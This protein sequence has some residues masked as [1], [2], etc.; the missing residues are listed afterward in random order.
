MMKNSGGYILL[1]LPL[2]IF[3]SFNIEARESR[4]EAIF[5]LVYQKYSSDFIVYIQNDSIYLPFEEVLSY[6][7]IYYIAKE[8]KRFEGY[9]NNA[10]S[11]FVIDFKLKEIKDIQGKVSQLN[12]DLWFA[13][14]FQIFIRTDLLEDLFKLK[15]R[16]LFNSLTISVQSDY[17]LPFLRTI[18]TNQKID[19][20]K[21]NSK[22]EFDF[23]VIS[24]RTFTILNGG[25]IDYTM[26][27]SQS[28][29]YQSYN[30]N[31]NAGL[32]LFSGE[33][34]YNT[35]GRFYTDKFD[36]QD[37]F[38]WRY[39]VD[40]D[41]IQSISLGNIQNMTYRNSSGRGFRKP[42][43]S[44]KGIQITNETSK[45]PNAFTDYVIEDIIEPDWTVELYL[46]DQLYEI[47]KADINGYYRFEIPITYGLTNIKVKLYGERG[48][49]ITEEKVLNIPSQL[50][51]PGELRYSIAAGQDENS[52]VKIA[53]GSINLGVLSWLTT[54]ISAIK[55]EQ[56]DDVYLI[57]QTA[58]NI[59]NNTLLNLTATNRGIFEAGIKLPSNSLG[60]FEIS[61]THFEPNSDFSQKKNSINLIASFNRIFSLPFAFSINGS[62]DAFLNFNTSNIY[63]NLNFYMGGMNFSI[64]HNLTMRDEAL[65]ISN[66]SQNLSINATYTFGNIAKLLSVFR[67]LNLNFS[68]YVNPDNWEIN[69]ISA[70]SQ[71]QLEKN[72][73]INANYI[74]YTYNKLS[75]LK[76]GINMNLAALRSNSNADFNQGRDAVYSTDLSGSVE[77]DSQ[78]LKLSFLNSM[79]SSSIYGKSSA[80]IRFYNDVNYNNTFD[81]EDVLIPEGDFSVMGSLVHK[82]NAGKYKIL[83]NLIPNTKYNIRVNTESFSNPATIPQL[84]EFSFIAAPYS[85]KSIDIACHISG[86]VEGSVLKKTEKGN[87]GFGGM[88]VNIKSKDTTYSTSVLV[89]SDGSYFINGIP[90]GDYIAQLDSNQLM[91]LNSISVPSEIDF[92]IKPSKDGDYIGNISFTIISNDAP[93]KDEP[94]DIDFIS[95]DDEIGGLATSRH[96]PII[97]KMT[98]LKDST[99]AGDKNSKVVKNKK[100][101]AVIDAPKDDIGHG[102]IRPLIFK[103]SRITFLDKEMKLYLDRIAEHMKSNP[104]LILKI[105]GHSDNSGTMQENLEVSLKRA[106]EVVSYLCSKGIERSRLLSSGRGPLY[107]VADSK[108][109]K[110]LSNNRVELTL[111]YE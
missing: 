110:K 61:Y 98:E 17:E 33:F 3:A 84:T 62:R 67:R 102:A 23:P 79:G 19:S 29:N 55:E 6:F 20:F 2:I 86:F 42:H 27:T 78:N 91:I 35:F 5:G 73:A 58:I 48:E 95:S 64:R 7:R 69:S 56:L 96:T 41:W 89:F 40:S 50:L 85:Y 63:S 11:S 77:F 4:E 15:F 80:A 100:A 99:N 51:V 44:L 105:E 1:F 104:K 21:A 93:S 111:S 88:R 52:G 31:L 13:T 65:K 68:T 46:A 75:N 28:K 106:G 43:Y 109:E 90:V 9:V 94:D 12:D 49:F 36:Y 38:R 10:D 60:N 70:G 22:D 92:S 16:T 101:N 18:R 72:I 24:D 57:N 39:L 74:Y 76:I 53:D 59:Y 87:Q 71:L 66:S 32:E 107:P 47:K 8:N 45:M 83:S 37:R 14:D 30:F 26:G 34:Q 81:D 108:S 54:S 82:S 25:I 103:K 97:K